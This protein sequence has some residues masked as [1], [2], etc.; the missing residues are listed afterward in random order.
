MVWR[1]GDMI[2]TKLVLNEHEWLFNHL[3]SIWYHSEPLEVPYFPNQFLGWDFFCHFL[4]QT[5][6]SHSNLHCIGYIKLQN[7]NFL[8]CYT[9]LQIVKAYNLGYRINCQLWIIGSKFVNVLG[10]PKTSIIFTL[11]PNKETHKYEAFPVN[12][13]KNRSPIAALIKFLALVLLGMIF[14]R[15]MLI[16]YVIGNE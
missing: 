1:I 4:Q 2:D 5:G 8:F 9:T 10:K 6:S 13:M 12:K 15:K 3:G 14:T 16:H 7:G 11:F